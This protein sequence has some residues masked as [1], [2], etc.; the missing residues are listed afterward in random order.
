MKKI[1][2]AMAIALLMASCGKKANQQQATADAEQ[3]ASEFKSA[4]FQTFNLRGDVTEVK[5]YINVDTPETMPVYDLAYDENG[6][7]SKCKTYTFESDYDIKYEYPDGK[8]SNPEVLGNID[9]DCELHRDSEGRLIHYPRNAFE[10][11]QEGRVSGWNFEGDENTQYYKF[12]EFNEHGDPVTG[13]FEFTGE[14]GP[15]KGI[16]KYTYL[17]YDDKGNW[18]R[19][20]VGYNYEDIPGDNGEEDIY[21]RHIQ[22]R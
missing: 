4:D 7:L 13:N 8:I 3:P 2:F 11:D 5:T 1:F 15:V 6:N 12:T 17:E 10:Y 21:I 14:E 18:T 16:I 22:Y 19:R 9:Y 20:S